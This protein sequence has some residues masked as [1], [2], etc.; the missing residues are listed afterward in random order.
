MHVLALGSRVFDRARKEEELVSRGT[1]GGLMEDDRV[2]I[3]GVAGS[4]PGWQVPGD[5]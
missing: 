4:N 5:E 3:I 2:A 1:K